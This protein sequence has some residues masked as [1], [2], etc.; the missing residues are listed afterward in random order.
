MKKSKWFMVSML[1]LMLAYGFTLLGCN[2][3]AGDNPA[4]NDP[5]A[6]N[7]P[8]VPN[9]PDAQNPNNPE[10]KDSVGTLGVSIA[11]DVGRT[12]LPAPVHF[13]KYVVSFTPQ[14]TQVAVDAVDVDPAKGKA[15]VTLG[16]GY[17]TISAVA[18]EGAFPLARGQKLVQIKRGQTT[19]VTI[20]VTVPKTPGTGEF[21]Y[22]VSKSAGLNITGNLK[23]YK[24]D[25]T[26]P[27]GGVKTITFGQTG[28]I[29]DLV[30]GFYEFTL[31]AAMGETQVSR[32]EVVH[33]YDTKNSP[34]LR[35][36]EESDFQ[37]YTLSGTVDVVLGDGST[38]AVYLDAYIEDELIG[39]YKID[40]ADGEWSFKVPRKYQNK[41][42]YF[43]VK[44]V[45]DNATTLDVEETV[46]VTK[47]EDGISL[48][49][50]EAKG[51]ASL[52]F[53]TAWDQDSKIKLASNG[54]P[55]LTRANND[56]TIVS[57]DNPEI[58]AYSWSVVVNGAKKV[59]GDKS[60]VTIKAEEYP[61]GIYYLASRVTID[62]APYSRE[63]RFEVIEGEK[64]QNTLKTS[65]SLWPTNTASFIPFKDYADSLDAKGEVDWYTLKTEV[66]KKYLIQTNGYYNGSSDYYYKP[67]I[68]DIQVIAHK[69]S[70]KGS[71]LF[72]NGDTAWSYP[73]TITGDGSTIHLE[74]KSYGPGWPLTGKYAIQYVEVK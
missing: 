74:V 66:G 1:G 60:S 32:Y 4:N 5:A 39:T 35:T 45:D 50:V 58:T 44:L 29:G 46:Q 25:E 63:F 19:K 15:D 69:G 49:I 12:V 37:F 30:P 27:I 73:Q 31:T 10:T 28:K 52:E 47:S 54:L 55:L 56:T 20:P 70:E 68:A 34:Y 38:P 22:D 64:N 62:E 65:G 18:Y 51:V 9:D 40:V 16:A 23:F 3:P 8:T 72:V 36:I 42:I 14:S 2:N 6:P 71:V 61:E 21:S 11:D 7:D 26:T 13:T 17:W 57:I 67:G 53:V 48:G 41:I 59:L 24:L 33:I 43:K